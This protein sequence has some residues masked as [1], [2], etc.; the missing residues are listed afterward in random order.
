M[1]PAAPNRA[2]PHPFI[3]VADDVSNHEFL[4][5]YLAGTYTAIGKEP[6]SE[7]TYSGKVIFESKKDHMIVTRIINGETIQGIGKIEH[8]RSDEVNVFR[9]RFKKK[10]ERIL[11]SHTYGKMILI[12][13]HVYQGIFINL[14]KGH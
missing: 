7:R 8:T 3:V 2:R 5:D 9:V 6:E 10:M 1:A 12:I 11:K 13:M 4:Y 14:G